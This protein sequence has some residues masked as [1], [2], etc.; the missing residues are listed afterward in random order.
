MIFALRQL[1]CTICCF[2]E[3]LI[4][5]HADAGMESLTKVDEP[6]NTVAVRSNCSAHTILSLKCRTREKLE[7]SSEIT[8]PDLRITPECSFCPAP[9]L[10]VVQ[11][12]CKPSNTKIA[13]SFSNNKLALMT[14]G[15]YVI[16]STVGSTLYCPANINNVPFLGHKECAMW[17]I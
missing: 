17:Q 3:A 11:T 16:N 10:L 7:E 5:L 1:L 8:L 2:Q 13:T 15:R 9:H 14:S 12:E 4:C 6:P